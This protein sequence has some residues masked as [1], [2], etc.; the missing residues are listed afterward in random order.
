MVICG[1]DDE[2]TCESLKNGQWT[3]SQL[4][5][6]EKRAD[7]TVWKTTNETFVIGG[8]SYY[9]LISSEKIAQDGK[10]GRGFRLRYE[11]K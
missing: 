5:L 11:A 2:D 1:G 6:K 10:I 8:S 3:R 7:S 9:A 4:R